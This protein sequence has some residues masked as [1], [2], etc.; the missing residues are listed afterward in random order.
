MAKLC[1]KTHV[2]LMRWGTSQRVWPAA[3]VGFIIGITYAY[4]LMHLIL[5][6]LIPTP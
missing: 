4:A 2:W 6:H 1:D 5:Y 3:L